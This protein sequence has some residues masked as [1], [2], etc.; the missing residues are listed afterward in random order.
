MNKSRK[1]LL[2]SL[3]PVLLTFL[4]VVY[5][6]VP[7]IQETDKTYKELNQEK[8]DFNNAQAQLTLLNQNKELEKKIRE[9]NFELKDFAYRFPVEN[10]LAIFLVDLEKYSKSYNVKVLSLTSDKESFIKIED[11]KQ[12]ELKAKKKKRSR[13]KEK[14]EAPIKLFEIPVSINVVGYYPNIIKFIN[15]LE[16]YQRQ[17]VIDG[18]KISNSKDEKSKMQLIKPKLEVNIKSKVY[19]VTEQK[20]VSEKPYKEKL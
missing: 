2:I 12:K 20:F 13:R 3:M 11:P 8:L 19:T 5:V 6:L 18:I 1:V 9:L 17:I 10:D 14:P 7:T 4:F 16:N 15:F